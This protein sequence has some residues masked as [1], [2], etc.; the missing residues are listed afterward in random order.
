MDN[1]VY[2]QY[3]GGILDKCTDVNLAQVLKKFVQQGRSEQ[4]TMGLPILL[5]YVVL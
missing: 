2:A 3:T 5:V 1:L 4:S